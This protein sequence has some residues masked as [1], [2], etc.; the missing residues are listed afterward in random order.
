MK[1]LIE[2]IK[3]EEKYLE[4]KLNGNNSSLLQKLNVFGYNS[5]T[6]YFSEK[7]DYMFSQWIPEVFYVDVKTLTT[8]LEKA[9]H[10][11]KYGIYISTANGLYAFH[12]SDEI[13]YALCEEL[14]VCVAE[15]Y[16][17]GGTIIGSNKDL[18]IEIVAPANLGLDTN[19]ILQ[20]ILRILSKYIDGAIVSGN[21]ILVNGKKI[22]GSM[23]RNVGNAFVW[24]AQ[25]SFEDRSDI[26]KK[27]CNKK[28]DKIPGYIDSTILTRDQL[29]SEVVA[30]LQKL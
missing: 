24:A 28:S 23:R 30:W 7:R 2:A 10:E 11:E 12:G 9:V 4:E 8:E 14:G 16:H 17:I 20:N 25:F 21:D 19:F 1:N 18:G 26:I 6:D 13:D 22:M 5:L 27:I 3:E 29:E 15:L